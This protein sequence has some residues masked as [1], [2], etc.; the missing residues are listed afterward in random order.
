LFD[1]AEDPAETQNG[2]AEHPD[3]A[4]R[5]RRRVHEAH[6]AFAMPAGGRVAIY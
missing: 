1:H 3:A 5:L 2:L 6:L 4:D